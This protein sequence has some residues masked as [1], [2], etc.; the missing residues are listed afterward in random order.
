M[1]EQEYLVKGST[2]T[3]IAN[4]IRSKTGVN[5]SFPLN[6]FATKI[7][8]ISAGS[9]SSVPT[10]T[11]FDLDAPEKVVQPMEGYTEAGSLSISMS[12][13]YGNTPSA[14]ANLVIF[15][16]PKTSNI[17]DFSTNTNHIPFLVWNFYANEFD[18]INSSGNIARK[19]Q[20]Y[21][22]IRPKEDDYFTLVEGASGNSFPMNTD[23][24]TIDAETEIIC[25]II[26][27]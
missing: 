21:E 24:G 14:G 3:G 23:I 5:G 26:E 25:M 19:S 8:S 22:S 10:F 7:N 12:E 27:W 11:G 2:L 20:T 16:I 6:T 4:A 9:G 17:Q 15:L 1:A 13:V 18:T